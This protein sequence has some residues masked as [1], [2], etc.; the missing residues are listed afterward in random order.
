MGKADDVL[1]MPVLQQPVDKCPVENVAGAC[2][3]HNGDLEGTRFQQP[4]VIQ[5]DSS[6]RASRDADDRAAIAVREFVGILDELRRGDQE[7][8]EP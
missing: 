8:D 5:K 4:A 2:G 6:F 3:V 7:I 1:E